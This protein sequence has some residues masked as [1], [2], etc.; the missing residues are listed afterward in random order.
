MPVTRLVGIIQ[1]GPG[2]QRPDPGNPVP[3]PHHKLDQ[4]PDL[5]I[6]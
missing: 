3:G 5:I 4:Y 1:T 6:R 2:E